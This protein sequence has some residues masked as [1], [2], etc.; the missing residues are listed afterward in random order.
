MAPGVAG[1]VVTSSSRAFKCRRAGALREHRRIAIAVRRSAAGSG[2]ARAHRPR[3]GRWCGWAAPHALG[4]G[5]DEGCDQ[6]EHKIQHPLQ[7][8]L[9]TP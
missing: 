4:G 9:G 8:K 6:R 7:L 2:C 5:M 3:I 1:A